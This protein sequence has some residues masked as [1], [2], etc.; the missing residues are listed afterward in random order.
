MDMP[1]GKPNI[2]TRPCR[3]LDESAG[4]IFVIFHNTSHHPIHFITIAHAD[5]VI[6]PLILD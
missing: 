4:F 5:A 2:R 6:T 1:T 3:R